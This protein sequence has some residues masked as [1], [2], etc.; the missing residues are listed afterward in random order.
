MGGEKSSLV[1]TSPPYN[2][3]LN[4]F[5]LSGMQA[6]RRGRGNPTYEVW[7]DRIATAYADSRPEAEYQGEQG[8]LLDALHDVTTDDA[9]VFL[10]H[11][12][13]YRD[14]RVVSPMEWIART[15]WTLRQEIVWDRTSSVVLNA[16]MFMPQDER[17]YWLTKGGQFVFN[18]AA[19]VKASGTVWRIAPAADASIAVPMFPTEIP[20]RC[21]IA[22][23]K[24][25]DVVLD[26]FGGSGTTLL[27]ADALGRR[28]FT[29][30]IDPGYCDAIKARYA[31]ASE[32]LPR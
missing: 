14:K 5:K 29:M 19:E 22:A 20:R 4:G 9:A 32:T 28:C 26:P 23:S 24:R 1:V 2:Q 11:K 15:R 30:E 10:N 16:R 8:A 21:I 17:V 7:V 25:G 12:H 6:E 18:D 13:R 31:A 27:A 3:K